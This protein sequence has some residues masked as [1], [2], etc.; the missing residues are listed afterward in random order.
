MTMLKNILK[1][2]DFS[3]IHESKYNMIAQM[4]DVISC[5]VIADTCSNTYICNII[6][7][8]A[9]YYADFDVDEKCN[10][11]TFVCHDENDMYNYL[12][13]MQIIY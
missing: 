10:V 13:N 2:H 11:S 6:V 12:C 8:D 4:L 1:K 3:I 7:D 5:I 9:D